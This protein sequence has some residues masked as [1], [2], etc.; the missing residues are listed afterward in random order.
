MVQQNQMSLS[1]RYLYLLLFLLGLA[2]RA[3]L[4][5]AGNTGL[6]IQPT[7]A[8]WEIV[9]YLEDAQLENQMIFHID[10][11]ADGSAWVA[12]S[13]GLHAYDG[14]TWKGYTHEDGL[15]DCMVRCVKVTRSGDL[16][17]STKK[18]MGVFDPADGSFDSHG[19]EKNLAGP[20]VR[21]IVEDPDGTLW[22]CSDRWLSAT[23]PGGLTSYRDGRW[24]TYTMADGL[25]SDYVINY[26]HDSTVKDSRSDRAGVGKFPPEWKPCPIPMPFFGMP[27]NRRCGG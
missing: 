7:P 12:A 9:S 26:F 17:V 20:N 18:G 21:R 4:C 15:P 14:F 16:W 25:P 23:Q 6:D 1:T 5:I 27:W 10:F 24:T 8:E 13:N 2:A 11:E 22:F 19:S 3:G